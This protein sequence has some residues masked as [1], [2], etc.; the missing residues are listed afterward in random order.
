MI[1]ENPDFSHC[2]GIFVEMLTRDVPGFVLAPVVLWIAMLIISVIRMIGGETTSFKAVLGAAGLARCTP[3]QSVVFFSVT[4]KPINL[5]DF[6]YA[7][8]LCGSFA[9]GIP[10]GV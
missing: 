7:L 8:W 6:A 1:M 10:L 4:R 9:A 3:R 5:Y 2:G